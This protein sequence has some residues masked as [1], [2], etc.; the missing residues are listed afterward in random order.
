MIPNHLFQIVPAS[1]MSPEELHRADRLSEKADPELWKRCY[2]KNYQPYKTD[3]YS[4]PKAVA[5][6]MFNLT[7]KIESGYMGDCEKYEMMWAC[8]MAQ[9]R[10]PQYWVAPDLLQAILHTTPPLTLDWYNMAFPREAIAFLLPRG[11]LTHKDEGNIELISFSRHKIGEDIPSIASKGPITWTSANG[12]MIF[13]AKSAGGFVTHWNMPYDAFP[14]ID[15]RALDEMVERYDQHEHTSSW[16]QTLAM[17]KEDTRIGAVV[18]HLIFGLILFMQRKPEIITPA[19][20]LKRLP[21]KKGETP[22]QLWSAPVLGMNYKIR[23]MPGPSL[24]GTHASP[25][26]HWVKG[27]WREQHYG[28]KNSLVKEVLIDPFLRGGEAA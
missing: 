2:P 10:V 26:E 1:W 6:L 24:G 4:P 23:R 27:Y 11:F 21:A 8:R 17:T 19:T 16:L 5:R 22:I 12:S 18:A 25:R 9:Q 13:I 28:E 3:I 7:K 15:L 20:R 14:A